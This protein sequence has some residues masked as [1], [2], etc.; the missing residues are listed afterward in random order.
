VLVHT[1]EVHM[2]YHHREHA[3]GL[4]RGR[5][6]ERFDQRALG[7]VR[8]GKLAIGD[9]ELAYVRAL[10]QGGV[11][12]VDHEVG[13]LLELLDELELSARTLVVLT[14]DHGEELGERAA[15]RVGMH[16]DLLYDVLLRV[17]LVVR[18]PRL[19]PP[20]RR[21]AQQVRLV[22]VF[23]TILELAGLAPPADADGRSLV[24]LLRGAPDGERP[25][26]AELAHPQ[27]QL[28]RRLAWRAEGWKLIVNVAPLARDEAPSE[29]YRLADDPLET[30]D[31]AARES[32]RKE[33]L[34]ARLRAQR[35]AIDHAGRPV[36]GA[37]PDAPPALRERLRALGYAE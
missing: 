29:L 36:L 28:A 26:Y 30:T 8:R 22:D 13:G 33:A 4:E 23:P 14:S 27:S 16:G 37:A 35:D 25:A 15:T 10:Y 2:P 32:A 24:P 12:A 21:V 6:P 34:L 18:D 17:P 3:A 19:G 1:Y 9:T 31:L 7:A 11:A 5:L 20:G